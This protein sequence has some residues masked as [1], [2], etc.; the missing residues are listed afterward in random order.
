MHLCKES[1]LVEYETAE[2]ILNSEIRKVWEDDE[3]YYFKL[4][5]PDIYDE[6]IWIINKKTNAVSQMDYIDFT[7][8][9]KD[10]HYIDAKDVKH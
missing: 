7:W 3:N 1:G 4:E 5:S 8:E 2:E 10:A 6:T 9:K